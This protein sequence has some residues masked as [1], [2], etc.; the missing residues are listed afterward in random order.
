MCVCKGGGISVSPE[1]VTQCNKEKGVGS[2]QKYE[3]SY[4]KVVYK[5]NN[6]VLK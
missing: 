4:A 5:E 3:N 2:L 6:K 1:S